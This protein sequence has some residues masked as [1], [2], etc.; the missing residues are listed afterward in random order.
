VD[1]GSSAEVFAQMQQAA[2]PCTVRWLEKEPQQ[3]GHVGS[4]NRILQEVL[5]HGYDYLLHLVGG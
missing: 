4:L 5:A 3:A 2:P 1:D